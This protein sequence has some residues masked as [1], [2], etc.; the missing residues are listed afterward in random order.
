VRVTD[1][2][3]EQFIQRQQVLEL[4]QRFYSDDTAPALG[5]TNQ[6]DRIGSDDGIRD[7]LKAAHFIP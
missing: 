2:E 1:S 5:E 3:S 7:D 6:Y 4:P